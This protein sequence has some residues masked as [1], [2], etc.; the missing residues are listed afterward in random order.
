MSARMA[1]ATGSLEWEERYNRNVPALDEAIKEA[2]ALSSQWGGIGNTAEGAANA[3]LME[4]EVRA[5]ALVRERRT[6][7]AQAILSSQEYEQQKQIYSDSLTKFLVQLTDR[8]N[9]MLN[10]EQI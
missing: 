7:E 5:L 6:A 3:T 1:A 8:L 10:A 2:T 9:T 4:M